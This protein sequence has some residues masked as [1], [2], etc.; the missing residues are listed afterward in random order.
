MNG[1]PKII[2]F[3]CDWSIYPGLRLSRME[4]EESKNTS[5]VIVTVCAGRIDPGLILD[6]FYRGAWGVMIACCPLG[7]CEHDGNYRAKERCASVGKLLAV[8]GV[9]SQ[10]LKLEHFATGETQ[11]LKNVVDSFVS[12]ITT[13][14]PI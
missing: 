8:L 4:L 3:C 9:E 2:I 13:L 14:G 10:R 6:T 5:E 11:K 12:E 1:I 7:E